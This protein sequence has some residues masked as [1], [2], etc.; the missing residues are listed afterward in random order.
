MQTKNYKLIYVSFF[1]H[2]IELVKI[3]LKCIKFF[4]QHWALTPRGD[5]I[6]DFFLNSLYYND[7]TNEEPS[8]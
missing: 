7:T 8:L 4:D 1:E 6:H 2:V 5:G 3:C